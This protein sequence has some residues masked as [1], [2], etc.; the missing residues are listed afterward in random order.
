MS[1]SPARLVAWA[2]HRLMQKHTLLAC[3]AFIGNTLS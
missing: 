1:L 2:L 3:T